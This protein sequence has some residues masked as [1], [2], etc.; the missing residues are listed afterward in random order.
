[1][2]FKLDPVLK[3]RRLK[4]DQCKMEIGRLNVQINELKDTII[5]HQQSIE[6]SY[7]SHEEGLTVGLTG[8]E[9]RFHPYFI[10]GKRAHID[11]I[12]SQIK[13]L[14]GELAKKYTELNQLRADVKVI[15]KLKEKELKKHKKEY[16]KKMN[17]KID[18][19][20]QKWAYLRNKEI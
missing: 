16:Q 18:E 9:L 6:Q 8:Q 5:Q 12:E 17:N 2:K 19:E 4:E 1:M 10:Q 15:E 11:F 13:M 20:V 7:E 3:I 14:E